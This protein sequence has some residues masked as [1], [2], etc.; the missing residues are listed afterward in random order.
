MGVCFNNM[1]YNSN[2]CYRCSFVH[3][4]ETFLKDQSLPPLKKLHHLAKSN[5]QVYTLWFS[6][7]IGD[8][9]LPSKSSSFLFL[10]NYREYKCEKLK[11]KNVF[12]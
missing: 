7:E 10:A 9:M 12:L 4:N 8:T 5:K 6:K 2:L 3:Y 1:I 11:E